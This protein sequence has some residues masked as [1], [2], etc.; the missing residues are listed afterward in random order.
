MKKHLEPV[1]KSLKRAREKF[2]VD[3]DRFEVAEN[4]ARHNK[5][6]MAAEIERLNKQIKEHEGEQKEL[7]WYDDNQN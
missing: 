3:H 6:L 4:S 2:Q 1:V 7:T 5:E